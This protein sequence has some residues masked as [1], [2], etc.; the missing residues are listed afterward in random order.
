MVLFKPMLKFRLTNT[1]IIGTH[2]DPKKN[3]KRQISWT[4]WVRLNSLSPAHG[5]PNR[6]YLIHLKAECFW[7]PRYPSTRECRVFFTV[8]AIKTCRGEMPGHDWLNR[9]HGLPWLQSG[10]KGRKSALGMM[11]SE[12]PRLFN[13]NCN[14][15]SACL[16]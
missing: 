1:L 11:Y 10:W 12:N 7:V 8:T 16:F 5:N 4:K 3:T 9:C 2:F 13:L 15:F 14:D 6:R